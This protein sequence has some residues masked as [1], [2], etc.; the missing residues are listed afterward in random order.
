MKNVGVIGAGTMGQGI[1]NA[2]A[3]AGYNVTVCDIKIEWAQNGINK[4]GAKLDKLVSREKITAEKAEGIKANL[5]AGEYK[6]LADCDL[7]VEAV[8]EKM[9][10]KKDLFKTLDEICKEDCIFGTN[11]S[12]L[13][14]TEIANGI[15]HNVIGMH[16]FNPA[17]RMKLVEVISGENTPVETKEAIIECSKSL[18]KTPVEVAEGPGFVVNR[19]LIPMI[20]EACFIYQEGLASVEDIDTAMKLG[21][22]HPMGPLALGDL[23]GLDIVLDVMEV[24]YTET[25]DPKYRPCTLLKK[26]VRAGKLGQ[27]TKQGFYSYN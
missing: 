26:M 2:F 17:D 21:A 1:A 4:I 10:I 15:K 18:G 27:K 7:I 9:E 24:L 22:N 8:L 6:D 20:N 14:V 25:G 23:I 19:I 13:S 3:T 5:T 16:F 12:S 11:T